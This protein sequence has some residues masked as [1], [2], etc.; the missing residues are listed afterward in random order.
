MMSDQTPVVSMTDIHKSFSGVEVLHGA[1]LEVR[2]GEVH[3][4][5]GGNGAGKSTLMKILQ[6]VYTLDAGRVEI[7]GR[8]VSPR[9]SSEARQAGVGMVFQEFSLIP[10]LTVAQNIYLGHEPRRGGLVD[11]QAMRRSAA[12]LM[13]DLKVEIDPAAVVEDLSTAQW[14]LVEIAKAMSGDTKVLIMDEPT[15]S[16]AS[17]E[18]GAL[19]ELV[20]H[21]RDQGTGIIYISHRMEE[22]SR[23]ADRVTV[24]RNGVTL[25]TKPI[26]QL[27]PQQIIEAVAGREIEA[28]GQSRGHQAVRRGDLVLTT[29]GLCAHGIGPIDMDMWAGEVVGLVG[30]MGAGRTA[31]LSALAGTNK[32]SAGQVTARDQVVSVRSPRQSIK[33][34]ITLVPEDRRLQGLVLEHSVVENLVLPRLEAFRH[35]GLLASGEMRQAADESIKRW[36]IKVAKPDAPTK[37]LS[38]GNQQKIVFAKWI[39]LNPAVFLLD[40]PTAGVDIGSKSQIITMVREIA[41]AGSAVMVASSEYPELRAMCDRYLV[42]ARGRIVKELKA[43][44]V[45]SDVDLELA[46]QGLK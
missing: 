1:D 17:D 4:L 31:L 22:I 3:A 43:D 25:W 15:A 10:T 29:R 7:G 38:G 41:Q 11:D 5:I 6:G 14:Q 26:G 42:V 33:A 39:G 40:E 24:L 21:L 12:Q 2:P 45:E 46:A 23:I 19:F 13:S 36:D 20:R 34:G 28:T 30:L 32:V 35:G 9:S 27:T 18:V 16:L 44:E 8:P 37:L